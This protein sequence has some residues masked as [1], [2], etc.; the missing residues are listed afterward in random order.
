MAVTDHL[1]RPFRPTSYS[2]VP[3][4]SSSPFYLAIH[5]LVSFPLLGFSA[6]CLICLASSHL[7]ITI[8]IF[9]ANNQEQAHKAI[10]L[11]PKPLIT[12]SLYHI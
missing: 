2:L 12:E 8:P 11:P 5:F 10:R 6:V 7:L 4:F 9:E 1:W 3:F